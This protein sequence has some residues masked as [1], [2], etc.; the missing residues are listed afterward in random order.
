MINSYLLLKG[1]KTNYAG[2]L[3]ILT[4]IENSE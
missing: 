2:V 4:D 1:W 3:I